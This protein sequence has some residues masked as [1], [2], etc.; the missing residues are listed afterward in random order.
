MDMK[1]GFKKESLGAIVVLDFVLLT[2]FFTLFLQALF[3]NLDL[4][5]DIAP[6]PT[7]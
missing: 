7:I 6:D 2:L 1:G 3:L 4:A 5:L